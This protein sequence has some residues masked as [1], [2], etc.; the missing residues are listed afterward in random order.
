MTDFTRLTLGDFL[1]H[2]NETIRRAAN[3]ILKTLVKQL[4]KQSTTV[5]PPVD[6]QKGS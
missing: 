5:I 6:Y 1:A 4:P 3:S 2:D